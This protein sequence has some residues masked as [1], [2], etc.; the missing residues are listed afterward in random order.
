MHSHVVSLYNEK[1]LALRVGALRRLGN[2]SSRVQPV[3]Q[4]R[5]SNRADFAAALAVGTAQIPAQ[6]EWGFS[7]AWRDWL[8]VAASIACAV[9]CAAMPFVVGFLP[10]LGLSFF[11]DPAFHQWMVA[12]CLGLAMLAFVPGWRRHRRLSPAVMAVGGLSLIAVAAFAGEDTCCP[13]SGTPD[14]AG[15][16]SAAFADVATKPTG[17][18]SAVE[19]TATAC[20][21]CSSKAQ[22]SET[23][24]VPAAAQAPVT[25]DSPVIAEATQAGALS[26]VWPWVTPLGG[27]LLVLAH[28]RNRYW[29]C[30]CDCAIDC[31]GDRPLPIGREVSEIS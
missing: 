17:T 9:H 21:G 13:A 28:L 24:E 27:V 10:L 19:C 18:D 22:A 25:A 11:A 30:R 16:V 2:R 20:S 3:E 31:Q 15:A 1:P 7:A 12:I 23:A 4:H 14:E 26:T 29:S 8:G 5:Q 6:P